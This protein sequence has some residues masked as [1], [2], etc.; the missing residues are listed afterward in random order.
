MQA[1]NGAENGKYGRKHDGKSQHPAFVQRHQKQIAE[2]QRQNNQKRSEPGGFNFLQAE[3]GP[4][5]RKSLGQHFGSHGANA[6]NR[7]AGADARFA[8]CRNRG[9]CILVVTV[10]DFRRNRGFDVGKTL[11]LNQGSRF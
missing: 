7:S 4:G 6:V 8:L 11:Y 5:N 10:N 3:A 9:I 2:N 1:D